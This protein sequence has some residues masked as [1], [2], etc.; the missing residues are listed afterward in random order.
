MKQSTYP[1]LILATGQL[2]ALRKIVLYEEEAVS[3]IS[4][5]RAQAARGLGQSGSVGVFGL[6]CWELAAE[7]GALALATGLLSSLVQKTA[8]DFLKKAQEKYE[9]LPQRSDF[10]DTYANWPTY[11]FL[12][13]VALTSSGQTQRHFSRRVSGWG[14]FEVNAFLAKHGKTR[15]DISDG[16]V[17]IS[18]ALRYIHNGDEFINVATDEGPASIRWSHVV[19][20][21]PP[22][23]LENA[24]DHQN[25]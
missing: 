18:L 13:P 21:I 14:R 19:T 25:G 20:Y 3:E 8:L 15:H 2:V 24:I 11:I 7:A 16:H 23:P 17:S 10:F 1:I 5:L 4:H 9:I 22:L 12:G 6:P